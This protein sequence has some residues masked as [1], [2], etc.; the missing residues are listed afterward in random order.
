MSDGTTRRWADTYRD[1][2]VFRCLYLVSPAWPPTLPLHQPSSTCWEVSLQAIT[3]P[4]PQPACT[5]WGAFPQLITKHHHQPSTPT[6]EAISLRWTTHWPTA[7]AEAT[8]GSKA[9]VIESAMIEPQPP[10]V[11]FGMVQSGSCRTMASR[12]SWRGCHWFTRVLFPA[13][14]LL[15]PGGAEAAPPW[16]PR[17]VIPPLRA[18]PPRAGVV[19]GGNAAESPWGGRGG[20]GLGGGC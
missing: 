5:T 20:G 15:L 3:T 13:P 11:L 2:K 16:G 10:K 14:S 6:W 1:W 8:H 17:A 12:H 4:H 7:E 9:D 18:C 19:E